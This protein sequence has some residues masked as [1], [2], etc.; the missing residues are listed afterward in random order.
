MC[1]KEIFPEIQNWNKLQTYTKETL[2]KTYYFHDHC[3]I[4]MIKRAGTQSQAKLIKQGQ[5]F[6]KRANHILDGYGFDKV[7][8]IT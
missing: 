7:I 4:E 8:E 5:D 2:S 1:K 6:I 3:Y